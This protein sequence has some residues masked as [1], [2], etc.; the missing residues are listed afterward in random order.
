MSI[1]F[2]DLLLGKGLAKPSQGRKQIGW[3]GKDGRGDYLP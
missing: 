3:C 2:K 1:E